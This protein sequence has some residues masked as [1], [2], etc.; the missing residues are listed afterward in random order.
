MVTVDYV[1]EKCNNKYSTKTE[2]MLCESQEY[3]KKYD[4][5]IGEHV[6]FIDQY[7]HKQVGT[8]VSESYDKHTSIPNINSMTLHNVF[9]RIPLNMLII[10]ISPTDNVTNLN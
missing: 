5:S 10:N 1:C 6:I 3:V 2:A 7:S 4:W 9:I 8:V